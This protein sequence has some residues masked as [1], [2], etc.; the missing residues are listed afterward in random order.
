MAPPIARR[1]GAPWRTGTAEAL[2]FA[3]LVWPRVARVCS[4]AAAASRIIADRDKAKHNMASKFSPLASAFVAVAA[5]AV[6]TPVR[7]G[8]DSVAFPK[9]YAMGV[10]YTSHDLASAKEF[11][12]FYITPAA[13]EAVRN[14]EPLPSGTVI[15]L[16]RY[17]VQRDAHGDPVKDAGGR[18]IKTELSTYRVMEKRTGWGTEYPASKRNG[19]WEYQAFLPDGRIDEKV[20]LDTCFQ[21]HRNAAGLDFM[22]TADQLKAAAK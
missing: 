8:G 13:I 9:N 1:F 10:M 17:N 22:F 6:M 16:A 12:E 20:D 5:I 19:E 2:R 3:F 7:A 14:G 18:F 4:I 15:T 11:R 21:C